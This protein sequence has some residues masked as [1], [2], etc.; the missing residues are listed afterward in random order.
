MAGK[1]EIRYEVTGKTADEARVI[2][3][4]LEMSTAAFARLTLAQHI[5][6]RRGEQPAFTA[7]APK[8]QPAAVRALGLRKGDPQGRREIRFHVS[9]WLAQD[10]GAVARE[11]DMSL[12][13]FARYV[14]VQRLIRETAE[15]MS[16]PWNRKGEQQVTL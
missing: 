15:K 3:R 5:E 11:L 9:D 12:N 6:E 13:N 14:L 2:A 1:T 8:G 7:P 4:S 16:P 10:A